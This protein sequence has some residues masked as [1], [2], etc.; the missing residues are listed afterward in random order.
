MPQLDLVS[1]FQLIV[2]V[3][4][5]FTI[6]KVYTEIFLTQYKTIEAILVKKIAMFILIKS[7]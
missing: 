6:T 1:F 4:V 3:S 2:A 5:G 7:F